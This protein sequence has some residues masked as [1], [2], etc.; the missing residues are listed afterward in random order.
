MRSRFIFGAEFAYGMKIRG[1]TL[2]ELARRANVVIATASSAARGRPVNIQ[3]AL[4]LAGV[5]SAAPV[6]PELELWIQ[7]EEVPVDRQPPP[8]TEMEAE[9]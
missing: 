4:K 1:L 7:R 5:V 3:T 8:E 2:T 9:G 6:I